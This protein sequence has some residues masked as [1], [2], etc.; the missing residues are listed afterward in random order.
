MPFRDKSRNIRWAVA[1]L[2]AIIWSFSTTYFVLPWPADGRLNAKAVPRLLPWQ[3]QVLFGVGV[4]GAVICLAAI[5]AFRP[6]GPR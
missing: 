6:R 4:M 5:L 1:I 2:G 3:E